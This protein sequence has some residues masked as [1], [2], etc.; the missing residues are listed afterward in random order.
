MAWLDQILA[1]AQQ[2]R[3]ALT[4][5]AANQ[6]TGTSSSQTGG[7]EYPGAQSA[8][9]AASPEAQFKAAAADYA[10][11]YQLR[12]QRHQ[13]AQGAL[14]GA[15]P[16]ANPAGAPGGDPLAAVLQLNDRAGSARQGQAF[17]TIKLGDATFHVYV[18]KFGK[19]QVV[20]LGSAPP[21]AQASPV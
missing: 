15:A 20:K 10:A 4:E 13:N 11:G 18:D 3:N 16:V 14:A 5:A 19:R 9:V 21:S 17:Q 6:A 1:A 2:K 12:G 7:M 8:A